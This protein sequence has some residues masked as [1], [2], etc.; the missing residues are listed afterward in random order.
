ME[1]GNDNVGLRTIA[2]GASTTLC[3]LIP[4]RNK[5]IEI[6]LDQELGTI[7]YTMMLN[8]SVSVKLQ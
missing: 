3:Q 1:A 8:N 6:N 4:C 2:Q 7:F 5:T